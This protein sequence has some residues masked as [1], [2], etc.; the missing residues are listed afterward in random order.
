MIFCIFL[1]GFCPF[2]RFDA[3]PDR[4]KLGHSHFFYILTLGYRRVFNP[5]KAVNKLVRR[6]VHRILG[7]NV[8]LACKACD[9]QEKVAYLLLDMSAVALGNSRLDLVY[10]LVKLCY[11]LLSRAKI[12]EGRL[13]ADFLPT[14]CARI[15]AGSIGGIERSLSV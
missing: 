7:V 1:K 15:S 10:L 6:L 2:L 12:K 14:F 4:V 8:Y 3:I 9:G 5:F 13:L 11:D